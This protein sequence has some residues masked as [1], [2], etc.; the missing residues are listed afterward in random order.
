GQL[1]SVYERLLDDRPDRVAGAVSTRKTSGSFYTPVALTDY[2]V[3]VTLG[4]LVEGRD[5][6]AILSLRVLDPAM[7]SGAFLVSACRFMAGGLEHALIVDGT[8]GEHEIAEP[9]RARFRRLV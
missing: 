6:A 7:G 8:L 3:R 9:D 1:G 2:L 5:A 4:P